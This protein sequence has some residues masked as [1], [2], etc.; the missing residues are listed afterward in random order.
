MINKCISIVEKQKCC[1]CG[2]CV[3]VCPRDAIEN[4]VDEYGFVYPSVNKDLCIECGLC[5]S[6]CDFGSEEKNAALPEKVY[7]GVNRDKSVLKSSSSGGVFSVLAEYVLK[8]GGAV[9]GCVYDE[10][11]KPV[12]ICVE[13]QEEYLPMRGSKYA[14]SDV[15]YVYREIKARLLKGQQVLF[16]GT[17]C[18]VAAVKGVVGNA[19]SENLITVDLICHGVPSALMFE[20]FVSYLEEK[21]NSEIVWFNFRSKKYGWQRYSSEFGLAN[22]RTVN[23]GKAN[24]FYGPAFTAGYIIRESCSNCKYASQDRVGDITIGDFWGHE[25]SQLS[26]DVSKGLS[27]FTINTSKGEALLSVLSEK[28][29]ME[30][31]DYNIA[32][33]GNKCLHAPTTKGDKWELYMDAMKNDTIPEIARSYIL[34]NKKSILRSRIRLLVPDFIFKTVRKIKYGK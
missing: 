31:V 24:E 32:V 23:I 27:L 4:K 33:K 22:G 9:C 7:A 6:V 3:N 1:G 15:G 21:Y 14:Q 29:D 12:H 18:Q 11:L 13:K 26:R 8:N 28:M 10:K 19:N 25:K 5:V 20:R 30:E 16:T 34:R 2:A 17:P